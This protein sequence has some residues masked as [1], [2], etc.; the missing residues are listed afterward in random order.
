MLIVPCFQGS[1]FHLT[2][3]RPAIWQLLF[4]LLEPR[5]LYACL[6]LGQIGAKL[7]NVSILRLPRIIGH[8]A[9]QQII[10]GGQL[11][12]LRLVMYDIKSQLLDND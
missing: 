12:A 9:Q 4:A 8:R 7:L 3:P 5:S 6:Q 10:S 11:P 1:P 2:P